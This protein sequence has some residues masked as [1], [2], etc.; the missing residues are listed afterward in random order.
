M[1]AQCLECTGDGLRARHID[2]VCGSD[3]VLG[4]AARADGFDFGRLVAGV[5]GSR[6]GFADSY[7]R[8]SGAATAGFDDRAL[9]GFVR[10]DRRGLGAADHVGKYLSDGPVCVLPAA[11]KFCRDNHVTVAIGISDVDANV[12]PW[13]LRH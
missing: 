10:V 13:G 8:V 3:F 1:D 6:T 9:F 12:L 2:P 4:Q 11:G 5:G 7:R